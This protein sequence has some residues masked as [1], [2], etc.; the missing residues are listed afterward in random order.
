LSCGLSLG[1]C[2]RLFLREEEKG[3][4]EEEWGQEEEEGEEME[5]RKVGEAGRQ[6]RMVG[7]RCSLL[8]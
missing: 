4:E 1:S 3:K 5:K 8:C 7:L 2:S 6:G